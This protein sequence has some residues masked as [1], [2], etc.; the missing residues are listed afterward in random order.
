MYLLFSETEATVLPSLALV[1]E[2]LTAIITTCEPLGSSPTLFVSVSAI[3]SN[4]SKD[5]ANAGCST[6]EPSSSPVSESEIMLFSF[7]SYG[8]CFKS[9]ILTGETVIFASFTASVLGR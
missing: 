1:S 3:T 2:S 7:F 5:S 8:N 4:V 9:E 6:I